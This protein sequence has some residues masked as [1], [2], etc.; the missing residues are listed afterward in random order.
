MV[1][2]CCFET[3]H[4]IPGLSGICVVQT[5]FELSRSSCLSPLSA[6]ITWVNHHVPS[7]VEACPGQPGTLQRWMPALNTHV[8]RILVFAHLGLGRCGIVG[9]PSF[10]L[11]T[12]KVS[13]P[14]P[15]WTPVTS[16]LRTSLVLLSVFFVSWDIVSPW[17]FLSSQEILTVSGSRC[18]FFAV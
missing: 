17:L 16:E 2:V 1:V 18:F 15:F 8:R 14:L 10:F 5:G 4:S 12:K 11:M 3:R 13:Y 6:N 9:W 7:D